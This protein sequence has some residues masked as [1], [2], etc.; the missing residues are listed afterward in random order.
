MNLGKNV[1]IPSYEE[2]LQKPNYP[3]FILSIKN[4]ARSVAVV[5]VL[6]VLLFG[7][8]LAKC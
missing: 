8:L 5:I 1:S 3:F 7:V 4:T 2:M 6:F